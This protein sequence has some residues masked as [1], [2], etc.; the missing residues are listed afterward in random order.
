M[1][2][3]RSHRAVRLLRT[4]NELLHRSLDKTFSHL[5]Q[6]DRAFLQLL[7]GFVVSRKLV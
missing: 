2:P 5:F 3:L 6:K 4:R 7:K 1:Q